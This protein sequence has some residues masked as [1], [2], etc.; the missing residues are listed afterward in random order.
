MKNKLAAK[1]L[2]Y[3]AKHG[4]TPQVMH[5]RLVREYLKKDATATLTMDNMDR[6]NEIGA[7]LKMLECEYGCE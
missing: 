2:A 7:E 4:V 3:K 6:L 1:K 5:N